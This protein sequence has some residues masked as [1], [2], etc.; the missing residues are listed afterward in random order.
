M[1]GKHTG[2]MGFFGR[3]G[4]VCALGAVLASCVGAANADMTAR[5]ASSWGRG[6]GERTATITELGAP[7]VFQTF[8]VQ[9]GPMLFGTVSGVDPF[10]VSSITDFTVGAGGVQDMIDLRTKW[11]FEKFATGQLQGYEYSGDRNRSAQALQRA[12]WYLEGELDAPPLHDADQ[13]TGDSQADAFVAMA[14][15]ALAA[16]WSDTGAVKVMNISWG[17]DYGSFRIGD[18]GESQLIL[19]PAPGA[20]LLGILGCGVLAFLRHR[21]HAPS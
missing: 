10:R 7:A 4:R 11:L 2:V 8:S 18:A 5:F 9:R 1:S 3:R 6:L 17:V 19:V 21:F 20:V 14:D 13:M 16:G 15:Q 12:I